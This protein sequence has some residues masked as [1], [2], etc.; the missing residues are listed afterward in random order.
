METDYL[1]LALRCEIEAA[2][3]RDKLSRYELSSLAESYRT[4][5]KSTALL[6]RSAKAVEIMDRRRKAQGRAGFYCR[7][8]ARSFKQRWDE[9][10]KACRE[11]ADKLV[12][13]PERDALLEK[14][15]AG[16]KCFQQVPVAAQFATAEGSS[17]NELIKSPNCEFGGEAAIK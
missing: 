14:G 8:H 4:L 1:E 2:R 9:E 17:M 3:A 16:R 12:P 11:L 13:C 6:D 7:C 15:S 5:A 10:A